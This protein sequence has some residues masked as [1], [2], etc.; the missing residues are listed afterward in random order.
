MINVCLDYVTPLIDEK[1]LK[2]YQPRVEKAHDK[3]INESGE[4]SEFLGWKRLPSRM[5][6]SLESISSI[7]EELREKSDVVVIIGIGGS[8]IGAKSAIEALRPYF[9]EET[10]ILF[11][12]H[13]LSGAYL[14]ALIDH[15]EDKSFSI[16]VISKSGTTTEPAIAF[17][18]LK[19][20][21]EKKVG[22]EEARRRIVA[23]TDSKKGALRH[24]A[25]KEGYRTFPVPDDVGGRYSVLSAVGLLPIAIAGV[26][27][28]KLLAGAKEAS[29]D[30]E[31]RSFDNPA[32][33][34]VMARHALYDAGRKIELFVHYEPELSHF[35]EWWK[36]LFGESEGKQGKGLFVSSAA[37][38]T[39]LHSLGQYIQEGERHLFESVVSV[40][41]PSRTIKIPRSDEDGDGL[42]YI[43]GRTLDDINK[44]AMQGTLLAHLDGG[45]PS[46][47]I[48]LDRLDARAFGY[49]V[50]FYEMSC[51]LSGYALGVN[52]FNQPGVEAYKR[53]MFALL[54]KP[55]FEERGKAIRQRLE[56]RK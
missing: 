48:E 20:L 41:E 36:Q 5:Q 3:I 35:S 45:V 10:E 16:N 2:A 23:T 21:L 33:R 9:S 43:A 1:T 56:D 55:G 34:Y 53:N 32:Y 8:Y 6:D 51:A 15:L 38:T 52:P 28:E 42:N 37:F 54:E 4:G 13:H 19:A 50:Y 30:L 11:A 31:H 25:E 12:G 39:D 22:K 24:L 40:K 46:V 47:I 49:L 14:K 17:R 7:A 27:I 29:R 18:T 44:E 26:D